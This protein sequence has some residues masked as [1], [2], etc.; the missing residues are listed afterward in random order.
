MNSRLYSR[1]LE[2]ARALKPTFQTGQQFH[3]SFLF[4]KNRLL[5]FASNNYHKHH[6]EHRFGRYFNSRFSAAGKEYRPSLHSEC[7][8][9]IRAGL[10]D[11]CGITLLNV[12]I[13]NH[14]NA[15]LAK[16][17]SNCKRVVAAL[18]PR[19]ICYSVGNKEFAEEA[20]GLAT[21]A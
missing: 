8:V 7:A 6:L 9:A 1:A 16:C 21:K 13:N 5:C 10:E 18:G 19:R 4:R 11:W 17:C 3:V 12:R 15:A 2:I 14:G 20:V